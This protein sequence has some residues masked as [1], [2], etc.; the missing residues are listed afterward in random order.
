MKKQLI[1]VGIIVILIVVGLSGCDTISPHPDKSKFIGSW[2]SKTNV[3]NLYTFEEDGSFLVYSIK[4]G[5]W[6]VKDSGRVEFYIDSAGG[7]TTMVY[8]YAFSN[9]DTTLTLTTPGS[10]ISEVFTKQ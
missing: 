10:T 4:G 9:S 8:N 2:M 6:S 7:S 1:I 5:T 3:F